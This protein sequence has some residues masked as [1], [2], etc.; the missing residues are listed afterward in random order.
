ML[1]QTVCGKKKKKIDCLFSSVEFT[2][3]DSSIYD[4]DVNMLGKK[5]RIKKCKPKNLRHK[6]LDFCS[7]LYIEKWFYHSFDYYP[8][9]GYIIWEKHLILQNETRS[10]KQRKGESYNLSVKCLYQ[11]SFTLGNISKGKDV[12]ANRELIDCGLKFYYKT[13]T[14]GNF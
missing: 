2:M 6:F 14:W 11:Q 9:G 8:Q 12:K 1:F 10:T 3:Q 13:T 4:S 7:D 5:I